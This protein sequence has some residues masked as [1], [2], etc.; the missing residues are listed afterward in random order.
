[1]LELVIVCGLSGSGKS[2]LSKKREE[3]NH[4]FIRLSSDE[5]RGVIGS[6]EEDQTVSGQVFKTMEVMTEFFLKSGRSVIIDATMLNPRAR[7]PFVELGRKYEALLIAYCVK[8]PLEKCLERNRNR[9]RFVPE[10]IIRIQAAKLEWP[11][12]E[13]FDD[14]EEYKNYE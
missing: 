3:N 4:R 1:M 12:K 8:T 11:T 7:K 5:L 13:E 6:G 14:V 9:K 2:W 10:E